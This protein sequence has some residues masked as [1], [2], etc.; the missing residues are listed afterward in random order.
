ML[1][2]QS[3]PVSA[4]N[5]GVCA[6]RHDDGQG[7]LWSPGRRRG[8]G[9]SSRI[10]KTPSALDPVPGAPP[11]NKGAGQR[12]VVEVDRDR[13]VQHTVQTG[14]RHRPAVGA[15]IRVQPC[16]YLID[17]L[18][19]AMRWHA[20]PDAHREAA[21]GVAEGLAAR[22]SS[23]SP[24]E[25]RQAY[26]RMGGLSLAKVA[27]ADLDTAVISQLPAAQL[28]LDDQ[29][30]AGS[31]QMVRLKAFLGCHDAVDVAAEDIARHAHRALVLA[32]ADAELDGP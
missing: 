31:L 8:V 11:G 23:C 26:G 18:S 7:V 10:C 3:A 27:A 12:G 13:V 25:I 24:A 15:A 14:W 21:I 6:A 4:T 32:D 22:P 2:C 28:A 16:P 1:V 20:D 30:E 5:A 17:A 29:L 19:E 9:A